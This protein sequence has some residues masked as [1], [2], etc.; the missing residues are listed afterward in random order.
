MSKNILSVVQIHELCKNTLIDHLGIE[1][2]EVAHGKIVA[3]MPVD[4][5]THQPMRLLHGGATMALA[6]TVGSVGSYVIVDQSKYDVVGMEINGNH[7]GNTKSEYVIA[8]GTIIHK[9]TK[10]HVWDIRISDQ[11]NN[12]ISVCRMT[13]MIIDKMKRKDKQ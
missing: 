1:F 2:I 3:R 5:R 9:G 10:T 8:T 7:I 6:E 12:P 11:L 4:K 13:N